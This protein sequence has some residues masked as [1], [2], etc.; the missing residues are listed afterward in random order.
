MR[1]RRKSS[2]PERI[3]RLL[4]LRATEEAY[5]LAIGII[6]NVLRA[7]GWTDTRIEKEWREVESRHNYLQEVR[8]PVD[9]L[10]HEL[11]FLFGLTTKIPIKFPPER[12]V[13]RSPEKR[14]M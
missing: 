13:K 7:R 8:K 3:R 12:I 1:F 11:G 4:G 14:S 6:E 5:L 2:L 10:Q 9:M